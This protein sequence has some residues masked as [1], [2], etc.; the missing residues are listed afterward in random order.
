MHAMTG[1]S[2][3]VDIP[4]SQVL[5]ASQNLLLSDPYVD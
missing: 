5:H 2:T 4:P 3:R 1:V